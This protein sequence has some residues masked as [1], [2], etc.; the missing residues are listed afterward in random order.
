MTRRRRNP[1]RAGA[2]ECNSTAIQPSIPFASVR[3][4]SYV[5]Q[6]PP[7]YY[8]RPNPSSK[9]I[10]FRYTPSPVVAAVAN[11]G[12]FVLPSPSSFPP[13]RV[14]LVGRT[15]PSPPSASSAVPSSSP[16]RIVGLDARVRRRSGV[17]RDAVRSRASCNRHRPDQR[18]LRTPWRWADR[19]RRRLSRRRRSDGAGI[20]RPEMSP[21]FRQNY[22]LLLFRL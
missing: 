19:F 16:P 1:S 21:E 2:S 3:R 10:G 14:S 8:P 7:L 12:P 9:N 11:R 17:G 15:G 20:R 13:A 6:L 5:K 22:K 18:R 4:S